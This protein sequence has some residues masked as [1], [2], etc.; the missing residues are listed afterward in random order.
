M[1]GIRLDWQIE[2]DRVKEKREREDAQ[3]AR[4]RRVGFLRLI[5]F[6]LVIFALAGLMVWLIQRRFEQID[7]RLQRLLTDTVE[8]EVAALRVGDQSLFLDLQRSATD[9]WLNSQQASFL[10]Y[11]QLKSDSDIQLT[12]NVLESVIDGSRARVHV[13]EIIDGI[14]YTRIWFYWRYEDGWHHVPPD[15]QFWGEAQMLERSTFTIRYRE[16]DELLAQQMGD[17]L[18]RWFNTSCAAIDCETVPY[19]TV[20]IGNQIPEIAWVPGDA[21]Q[22][23]IP[24]PYVDRARTDQ[25]FNTEYQIEVA[26][27]LATRLVDNSLAEFTPVYPADAYYLR[28]SVISWLVG[29]FVQLDTNAHLI[30]SLAQNY[31]DSAVGGLIKMLQPQSS[32]AIFSQMTGVADVSQANLDWRDFIAWRLAAEDELIQRQDQANF[33]S[34]YDPTNSTAQQVA[35]NRFNNPQPAREKVVLKTEL[36][37]GSTPPQLNATVRYTDTGEEVVIQFNLVDNVWRRS[38]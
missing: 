8:A 5:L 2:S 16:V 12:G 3:L 19:I 18:E 32:M 22:M 27:L 35:I 23:T 20:D 29:R 15:Y 10:E 34:L 9:S 31:G 6:I 28:S 26:T 1:S 38:N 25:P 36:V 14:S 13:E 30:T 11:Q 7:Q 37:T 33:M 21:W 4:A 24:S 17:Q